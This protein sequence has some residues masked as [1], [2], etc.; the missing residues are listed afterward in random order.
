[1]S[2][3]G[4]LGLLAVSVTCLLV[5]TCIHGNRMIP[6]LRGSQHAEASVAVIGHLTTSVGVNVKIM[7]GLITRSCH[8]QIGVEYNT[9]FSQTNE[10]DMHDVWDTLQK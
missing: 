10:T 7:L 8:F 1:M 5:A 9:Y 2:G 6:C 4:T 3:I